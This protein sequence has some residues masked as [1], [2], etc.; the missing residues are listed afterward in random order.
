MTEEFDLGL[1]DFL[2]AAAAEEEEEED[3]DDE[4]V[5]ELAASFHSAR[6]SSVLE[7][8]FGTSTETIIL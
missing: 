6:S 5:N 4:E 2:A 8:H 1:D 3:D 7:M